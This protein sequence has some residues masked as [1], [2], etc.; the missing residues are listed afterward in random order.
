[1][2]GIQILPGCQNIIIKNNNI[3]GM[4]SPNSTSSALASYGILSWGIDNNFRPSNITIMINEISDVRAIGISF[5]SY[6]SN[7]IIQ[8]NDIHDIIAVDLSE[9]GFPG[10]DL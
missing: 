9:S 7:I 10:L 6:S 8:N 5:G 1:M 4:K 2:C 3:H